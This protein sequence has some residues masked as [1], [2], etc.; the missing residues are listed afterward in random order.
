MIH[1]NIPASTSEYLL[2]LQKLDN[3]LR[4]ACT[5]ERSSLFATQRTL[6]SP[7]PVH[8]LPPPAPHSSHLPGGT[9]PMDLSGTRRPQ[10]R[11]PITPAER[12]RHAAQGLC[13]YCGGPGHFAAECPARPVSRPA[14]VVATS[15]VGVP[16]VMSRAGAPLL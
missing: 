4:D 9:V 5:Q 2:L 3:R 6:V 11:D 7:A 1:H 10:C 8:T 16:P 15:E 12:A 14:R 13:M